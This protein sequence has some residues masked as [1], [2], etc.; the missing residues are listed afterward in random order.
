VRFHSDPADQI[1]VATARNHG[2]EL[3]MMDQ[4]ILSYPHV[5][6]ARMDSS[7]SGFAI[8]AFGFGTEWQQ[9]R[10]GYLRAGVAGDG[11]LTAR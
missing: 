9:R 10:V 8:G 1:M 7:A 5:T 2:S 4:R 6:L 3:V 11:P